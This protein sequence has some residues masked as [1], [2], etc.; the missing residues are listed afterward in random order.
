MVTRFFMQDYPFRIVRRYEHDEEEAVDW[1]TDILRNETLEWE[2]AGSLYL[3]I[4]GLGGDCEFDELTLGQ[5]RKAIETVFPQLTGR[6]DCLLFV[7]LPDP[8][9]ARECVPKT[10]DERKLR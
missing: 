10:M 8:N 2:D 1:R 6:A 5:A 7:G 3:S 4:C 9:A